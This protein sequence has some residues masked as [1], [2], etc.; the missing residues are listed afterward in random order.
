MITKKPARESKRDRFARVAVNRTN[1]A[2]EMIRLIGN[3]SNLANY[4]YT[5][6][7]VKQIFTFLDKQLKSARNRFSGVDSEDGK[8]SLR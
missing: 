5:D 3:C 6:D 1:K 8:F 2:A 7:E 4:D